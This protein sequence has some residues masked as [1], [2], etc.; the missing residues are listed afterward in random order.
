MQDP[1]LD[2]LISADDSPSSSPSPQT[3]NSHSRR[4]SDTSDHP[5]VV[6]SPSGEPEPAPQPLNST[7]AERF[8]YI[9]CSS[10]LLDKDFLS[11]RHVDTAPATANSVERD[12][13]APA[14]TPALALQRLQGWARIAT[15]RWDIILAGLVLVLGVM[16]VV[17]WKR[18]LFGMA[19]VGGGVGAGMVRRYR[20][21]AEP[22]TPPRADEPDQDVRTE[23]DYLERFLQA[24][25][26]FDSTIRTSLHLLEPSTAISYR[27]TLRTA[28][29]QTCDTLNDQL[30]D[31]SSALGSLVDK[32]EFR[33]LA[34][35]YDIP[36][37]RGV[38]TSTTYMDADM[39]ADT[40]V[41][42]GLGLG[43]IPSPRRETADRLFS[44][45]STIRP[46]RPRSMALA[47]LHTSWDMQATRSLPPSTPLSGH[48][49]H[50]SLLPSLPVN[51]T[52]ATPENDRFTSLPRRT[53]RLSKRASWDPDAWRSARL[54]GADQD[55]AQRF[56]PVNIQSDAR[57]LVPPSSRALHTPKKTSP[58]SGRS[59]EMPFRPSLTESAL[60]MAALGNA[61]CTGSPSSATGSAYSS[62]RSSLQPRLAMAD[63]PKRRSLQSLTYF[64]ADT[65]DMLRTASSSSTVSDLQQAR[66]RAS[67]GSRRRRASMRSNM[68]IT[69]IQSVSALPSSPLSARV[70][71]SF[72]PGPMTQ[73]LPLSE[74]DQPLA[75]TNPHRPDRVVSL[76]PLTHP[77][78]QAACLGA[79]LRRRRVACEL[80]AL[81]WDHADEVTRREYWSEVEAAVR[82]LTAG[83]EQ[84]VLH[85]TQAC[86]DAE[87]Q[88]PPS[89]LSSPSMASPPWRHAPA[90]PPSK[91]EW[92]PRTTDEQH[93]SARIEAIQRHLE[94][95]WT[96]TTHVQTALG[97]H[98]MQDEA[99]LSAVTQI[100]AEL[101]GAIG[102]LSREVGSGKA[103]L[104]DRER[105]LAAAI[106]HADDV[107]ITEGDQYTDD[108]P[109]F[110]QHWDTDGS[111]GHTARSTSIGTVISEPRAGV[112]PLVVPPTDDPRH[113]ANMDN[114]P[115]IG[116]DKVYEA[117]IAPDA[118]KRDTALSHLSRGERIALTKQAREMG[119]TLKE[120]VQSGISGVGMGNPNVNGGMVDVDMAAVKQK[121]ADK[122]AQMARLGLVDEL[123]GMMG[124]IQRRK[125]R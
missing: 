109:D 26:S 124:E 120:L 11:D 14:A 48:S 46:A 97:A 122:V 74:A 95:A 31:T 118:P 79:H 27:K 90:S 117:L 113:P 85:L 67:D 15:A 100:W 59:H 4:S 88:H 110:A 65:S 57:Q 64:P 55:I 114:L 2:E 36:L 3:P 47:P 58:L 80:L 108:L 111:D 112:E 18:V 7:A 44:P 69:S 78:L 38:S 10:G 81:R 102:D 115:A 5:P 53:P 28:L 82:Q 125:E 30:A 12:P 16:V 71:H 77:A 123:R 83:I 19:A 43:S 21:R 72:P 63:N 22:T 99:S 23:A 104:R 101:Q 56:A 8:K 106:L 105:A 32:D 37:G 49:R 45:P 84:A 60:R 50:L 1:L 92:A 34:T 98:G 96:S 61:G 76:S 20:I 70:G 73:P 68:S 25:R 94:S 24:S 62:K 33:V 75:G 13:P 35:M 66:E 51:I 121:Q 17:G 103:I 42:R 29:H 91:A 54:T 39:D 9:I 93:L 41:R 116:K 6:S 89:S 87:K 107:P 119:L 52:S 86:A 40:D